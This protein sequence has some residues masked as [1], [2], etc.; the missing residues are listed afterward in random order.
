MKPFQPLPPDA[1]PSP[2][3]WQLSEPE[4]VQRRE[5]KF[6]LRQLNPEKDESGGEAGREDGFW[7]SAYPRRESS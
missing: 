2:I 3:T 6:Q 5:T 4:M 7:G 1:F